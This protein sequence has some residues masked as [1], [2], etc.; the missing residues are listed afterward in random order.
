MEELTS[1]ILIGAG[2]SALVQYLKTRFGTKS[3]TT[4][5]I[6]IGI[7]IIVGTVYFLLKD[8]SIWTSVLSILGFAGA[9]YTFIIK[10]FE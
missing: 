1:Y 9:V 7:S 6:V 8:T 3:E 10:R 4:I 2:V 5:A